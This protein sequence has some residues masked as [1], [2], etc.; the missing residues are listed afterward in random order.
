MIDASHTKL[1]I[2]WQCA[3]VSISKF[4]YYYTPKGEIELNL[5]LMELMD[6]QFM[7]TPFYGSRQMVRFLSRQGYCVSRK[8]Y[9]PTD[10]KDGYCRNLSETKHQQTRA[11]A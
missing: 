8:A 1:S 2:E 6:V 4:C 3:L 11:W 10:E 5:R 9:P 7:E